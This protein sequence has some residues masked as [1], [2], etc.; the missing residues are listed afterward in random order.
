M[1]VKREFKKE[2]EMGE[3]EFFAK[4]SNRRTVDLRKSAILF[5]IQSLL[6]WI[7]FLES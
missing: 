3:A 5:R 6:N 1:P 4:N 7:Q 2:P